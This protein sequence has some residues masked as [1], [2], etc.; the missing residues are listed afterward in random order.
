MST[1]VR[2]MEVGEPVNVPLASSTQLKQWKFRAEVLEVTFKGDIQVTRGKKLISPPHWKKGEDLKDVWS[3][4]K[5]MGLPENAAY[6]KKAAAMLIQGAAGAKWDVE[7]K[8]NVTESENVSQ[9]GELLG[10]IGDLEITGK[11]PLRVGQHAVKAQFKTLPDKIAWY[12]CSID[13]GVSIADPAVSI[14]LGGTDV[15]VFFLPAVPVVPFTDGVW[16]EALR[17]LCNRVGVVGQMTP[18]E[19]AE[20]VTYYCHTGHGLEYDTLEGNYHY[21][22][23]SAQ[24][25]QLNEYMQGEDPECNCFDQAS[26]V[27][28][29]T[30]ALGVSATWLFMFPF[31]Y[32]KTANLV[33]VGAC[34]NPG[35]RSNRSD[36]TVDP[37]SLKRTEFEKHAFCE[38]NARILD[39]CVGPHLGTES[40]QD[41]LDNT[42]DYSPE[43]YRWGKPGVVDDI[44]EFLP[45]INIV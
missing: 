38:V 25:F 8:V 41:Y 26:A 21:G 31:G 12:R 35:Y 44:D 43:L 18:S 36:K 42:I 28:V 1:E 32:I 3:E 9:E 2:A 5:R 11:I 27:Q 7:I 15:E 30:A 23:P 19:I 34:N 40:R 14:I 10:R 6:S 20:K 45:M 4:A 16:A 24:A 13:W 29:L 39:A 37:R 17:F 22:S 33:G